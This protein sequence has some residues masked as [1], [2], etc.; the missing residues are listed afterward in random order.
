MILH[1]LPNDHPV[2]GHTVYSSCL[3]DSDVSCNPA[4]LNSINH[5]IGFADSM[6]FK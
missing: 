5:E 2:V 6:R 4:N 1:V 3:V